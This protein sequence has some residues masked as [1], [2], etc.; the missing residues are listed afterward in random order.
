[1]ELLSGWKEI[2]SHLHLTVRTAQRWEHLGLPVRRVSES[3]CSP[4]VAIPDEIE[5]WTRTRNLRTAAGLLRSNKFLV[6]RPSESRETQSKMC[7]QARRLCDELN[8]LQFEQKRL[9][10]LIRANLAR[11]PSLGK[12]GRCPP[13]IP[14]HGFPAAP[15]N[16]NRGLSAGL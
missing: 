7:R 3:I 4:V 1:M 8:A 6:T 2:A 13:T 12:N 15:R 10:S 16:T 11:D 9:L 14:W 5:L